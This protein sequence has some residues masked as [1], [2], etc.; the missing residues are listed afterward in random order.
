MP[1][2]I[3]QRAQCEMFPC[4]GSGGQGVASGDKPV[5]KH[6]LF[7]AAIG[8]LESTWMLT[9]LLMALSVSYHKM[10]NNRGQQ[11]QVSNNLGKNLKHGSR[12]SELQKIETI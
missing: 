5:W 12:D 4:H 11:A 2:D 1:K 7:T 10:R 3:I 9:L 8:Y 6:L